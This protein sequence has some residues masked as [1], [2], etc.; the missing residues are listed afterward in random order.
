MPNPHLA[1]DRRDAVRRDYGFVGDA[2]IV[3]VRR[4]ML[5]YLNTPAPLHSEL[6]G[7]PHAEVY[8]QLVPR[9]QAAFD[10]L[11]E[12]VRGEPVIRDVEAGARAVPGFAVNL[13]PSS[14]P[15]RT[16]R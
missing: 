15:W 14:R 12:S 16:A 3:P 8:R 6:A 2:L 10:A 7:M 9:D 11:L 1:Q 13:W 5:I 4:A